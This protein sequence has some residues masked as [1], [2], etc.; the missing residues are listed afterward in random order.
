LRGKQGNR[1]PEER[2]PKTSPI[3]VGVKSVPARLQ[4]KHPL[5]RFI[6]SSVFADYDKES[7]QILSSVIS[8][9]VKS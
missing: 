1:D 3:E 5:M 6:G 9:I 2:E 8:I 4:L 7:N